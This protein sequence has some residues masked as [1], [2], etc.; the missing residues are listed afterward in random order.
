MTCARLRHRWAMVW[1]VLFLAVASANSAGNSLPV[2]VPNDNRTPAGQLHNGVLNVRLEL[3]EARWYPEKESGCYR[4]VYAFAE[5]G[6]APQGS[7]PLL[8]VPQGTQIHASIHNTLPLAAKIY[9]LHQHPG[10]ANEALLLQPR[11]TRE[12]QFVAGEPGMYLYWATTSDQ[13]FAQRNS[14]EA[15]LSGAFVV[16]APGAKLDDRVFVINVWKTGAPGA[17][18]VELP[19]INGKSFPYTERLTYKQGETIHWRVLNTS[20]SDHAMHLHGFFF[21][22]QGEGDGERYTTYAPELRPHAVTQ[23][24]DIGHAFEMTWTPDRPGNWLFHCHMVAHMS[25]ANAPKDSEAGAPME[26]ARHDENGTMTGMSGLVLRVTVTP[27]NTAPRAAVAPAVATHKVQLVISDN[28]D[29]VPLYDVVVNDPRL[30]KASGDKTPSLVGPPIVLTRGEP[31]EIEVKNMTNGPTVIHWHGVEVES[32]Y[33]G[34]PGWTGSGTQLS[35]SVPAGTSFVA[36]MT[37][38]RSGTFVYHTHWHDLT[39]LL[40]GV[41]GAL[42]VLEP[43]QKYDP[44]HDRAI[45]FGEG[46]YAPFG[47][48]LLING[49][50]QPDP[51]QLTAGVTYH[52]RLI[53]ITD[54][55][56]DLHVRL[57]NGSGT[58]QWKVVG[59]DG[60]ALPPAQLRMSDANMGITVGEVYDVE[61]RTDT[62]GLV[63]LDVWEPSYPSRATL[64][65]DFVLR[66]N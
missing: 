66:N 11:E 42:I 32:Y 15:L 28:P 2:V 30:P 10:D 33:D 25:A 63:N 65:L 17:G 16:D 4:D 5:Q 13:P 50:P 12:L 20:W 22:I 46:K 7:G 18:L 1:L 21:E 45:V 23:H 36:H 27:D 24:I 57:S 43:G 9:G 31:A 54:D 8:R 48:L 62:P 14:D 26:A 61:Y 40:N 47:Y 37:P 6:A 59:K 55:S 19:S 34:V 64:P 3:R 53:N 38:P 56:S 29:K 35:P 52:L 41:Y 58:V 44:E 51:V 39:Q 60:A 49:H